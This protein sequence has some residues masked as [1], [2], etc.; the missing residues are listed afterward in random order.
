MSD[1]TIVDVVI[2]DS[3]ATVVDN[4]DLSNLTI[5][6]NATGQLLTNN[7]I[8]SGNYLDSEIAIVSGIAQSGSNESLTG[9]INQLSGNLITTGQTLQTQ[10]TSND[11]DITSLTSNL[12]TTGQTL[13]TQITSNDSDINTLTTNLATTGETLTSEINSIS[14]VVP[15]GGATNQVLAKINSA[16]YN[17]QWVDQSGGG[18]G[19]G[20]VT[21]STATTNYLTK[22]TNGAGEVIGNSVAYDD[23][24]NIGIGTATPSSKLHA[25]TSGGS[26]TSE[27]VVAIFQANTSSAISSGGGTAIKF[28]GVSSGGNQQNYD[29]GMISTFGYGT[30]NMHGMKFYYKPNSSTALTEGMRLNSSGFLSVGGQD[31]SEKLHVHGGNIAVDNTYTIGGVNGSTGLSVSGSTLTLKT[32]SVERAKISNDKFTIGGT[33]YSSLATVFN[34]KDSQDSSFNSGIGVFRSSG[35]EAT[36]LNM[37]GGNFNLN[38]PTGALTQFKVDGT[39]TLTIVANGSVGIGTTNPSSKLH[40]NGMISAG[41]AGNNSANYAALLVSSTGTGTQ[42]SAIAIQQTYPNGSTI[43]WADLEPYAEYNFSHN[44][45]D[46]A[47]TFNSG[48]YG[49]SLKSTTIRNRSGTQ[50]TS[51]EKVKIWQNTAQVDVGGAISIGQLGTGGET[52]PTIRLTIKDLQDSSFNSGIALVRSTNTATAYINMVGGNFN[53]NA[54]TGAL[55]QFKVAGTNT[56]T[57]V[58]N[59][60][61]GIG[62]TNPSSKLHVY[63]GDA[64]INTLNIGLGAGT[65]NGANTSIGLSALSSNTSGINNTAVGEY[66]LRG[67]TVGYNN[68][69]FGSRALYNSINGNHNTAIGH[70]AL[71]SNFSS[72]S[73]TAVGLGALRNTNGNNNTAIGFYSLYRNSTGTYNVANGFEAGHYIADGSTPNFTGDFNIFIGSDTKALADND[74][75]EIVIGYNATGAGS[76]SVTL[77]NDSV[78]KTILKG[79]VEF[80]VSGSNTFA[81]ATNGSISSST[82]ASLSSGGAWTDASTRELKQDIKDLDYRES[83][84]IIKQLNPVK[85]AYKKDP[86]NKKIGFIAEDVPDLVATEDRKGLSALQIVSA[87]TKVVQSQQKEIQQLKR[88]MKRLNKNK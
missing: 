12:V 53:L 28:K 75:N 30:N 13:Q 85:F 62:T 67:N 69:A 41:I 56:L 17:T 76:N 20:T 21:S 50:R 34:V 86:K 47:F 38:V 59:G 45:I 10:I 77:G 65:N 68:A 84:N 16:N 19:S 11:S 24:S 29:Q 49:N 43:I 83:L 78:T 44:G 52:Q 71:Y 60:S 88:M 73:N 7:L 58:A 2:N 23:G 31:A 81:V 61:V 51:F 74:Q 25:L 8:S 32:G 18:G 5:D 72:H 57:I 1:Q 22:W 9:Q 6:L 82:G 4:R 26:T 79:V 64:I 35:A 55:T 63:G 37:V 14:G 70:Y 87:L 39:N 3:T 40:V 27:N 48:Y 46:N 33:V 42:Q 66:T 15:T 54:P 80:K 36:Y